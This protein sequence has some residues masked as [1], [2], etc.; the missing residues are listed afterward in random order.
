MKKSICLLFFI[1]SISFLNLYAQT[2]SS[3]ASTKKQAKHWFKQKEW[4]GGCQVEPNKT[5]DVIEF[6]RQYYT[7]KSY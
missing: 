1:L 4:L 6:Y 7:Y 5:I 2:S 3:K